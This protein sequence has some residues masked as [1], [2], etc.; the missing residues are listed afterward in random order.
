MEATVDRAEAMVAAAE[1]ADVTLM[2]AYRMHTEPAVRRLRDLVEAGL[3]GEPVQLHGHMS[4]RLMEMI[5]NPDQW[6]L[7]PDLAGPGASVTDIGLYPLNT[8][9]YVLDADPVAVQATMDSTSD[10]FE[11][12]PDERAAFTLEF[13][14]GV[15]AACTASQNAAQSSHLQVIGTEGTATLDP[16]FFAAE[17]RELTVSRAGTR[18]DTTFDQVDQ[19]REEFDYFADCLHDDR[20]PVGNGRHGLVDMRALEGIYQAGDRGERVE[21]EK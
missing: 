4:Q 14:D 11:A 5:P 18:V 1:D 9:R 2:V 21:L 12:V 19:M 20:E 3:L 7:N 10:A 6:R 17:P 16:A 15:F 8:A 13:P